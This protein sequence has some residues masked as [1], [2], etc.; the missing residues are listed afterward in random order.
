M[1]SKSKFFVLIA[2]AASLLVLS[3]FG[4]ISKTLA[5]KKKYSALKKEAFLYKDIS[6]QLQVFSKKEVYYDSILSTMNLTDTSLEN[7]LL[8]TLNTQAQKEQLKLKNFNT[9]H[10]FLKDQSQYISYNFTLEGNY[11]NILKLLH[12]I[13][14]SST[15]GEIIHVD[16]N[17]ET[18]F[19]TRRKFL[20]AKVLVQRVQ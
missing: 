2:G 4:A 20:T 5:I 7:N 11:T 18:N 13:E 12:K 3:Y 15:F 10:I 1:N 9:P 14:K 8:K 19:R 6:K 16:F 17:Q